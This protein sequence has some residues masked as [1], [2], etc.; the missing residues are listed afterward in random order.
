ME[1]AENGISALREHVDSLVVIP[2]ERLKLVN[3]QKNYLVE[4]VFY[5]R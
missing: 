3:E 2:N 4:C 1:Q 5:R